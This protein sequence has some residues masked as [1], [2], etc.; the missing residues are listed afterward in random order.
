MDIN[1]IEV[2]SPEPTRVSFG[3]V[4]LGRMFY[5]K[6]VLWMRTVVTKTD[7]RDGTKTST[8]WAGA[9]CLNTGHAEEIHKDVTVTLLRRGEMV[10][11]TPVG[12]SK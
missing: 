4:P 9:V 1:R 10:T 3:Q 8:K 5:W 7:S 11:L 12:E 6:G 2:G